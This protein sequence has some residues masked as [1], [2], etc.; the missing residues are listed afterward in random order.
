MT[1]SREIRLV[2]RPQGLPTRD[3]F[4]LAQVDLPDPAPGQVQVRNLWMSVDPSMRGRMNDSGSLYTTNYRLGEP[5]A[6][7]AVGQVVA[8]NAPG[9]KVGDHVF[10]HD[11]GWR[12][13]YNAAPEVLRKIELEGLPAEAFL[14]VAGMTGLTAYAGLMKIAELKPGDMVLVTAAAGAVGSVA[15]QI[16]KIKGHTVIGTAGGPAKV[17]YLRDELKLDAVVDYREHTGR[18]TQAFQAAAPDGI[19]VCFENVG[20]EH[21]EAALAIAR[22]YGRFALC[23]MIAQY[24]SAE[25]YGVRNLMLAI[26]KQLRLEGYI[27]SKYY[28]LFP[29]YLRE[30]RTW[31]AEGK[32]TWRQ[33]VVEGLEKA[34]EAFLGLFSGENLGKALVKL[35]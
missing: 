4:E 29:E 35:G 30:V 17:A 8:S 26:G 12:E 1:R 19:D 33:T 32:L 7:R 24:N 28:D 2:K 11:Y 27:L 5:M 16:A 14:S 23:G 18:L 34:P 6:G 10:T 13:A 3:C 31:V 21:L 22:T 9:L 15:A 25:P 20:G